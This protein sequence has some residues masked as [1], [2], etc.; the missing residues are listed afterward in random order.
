MT[1]AKNTINLAKRSAV[2][3]G[4]A[5]GIGYA[6]AQRLLQSGAA[7][8][9]WDMDA[10]LLDGAREALATEG[11]VSTVQLDVADPKA[12][13]DAVKASQ[14]AMGTIEIMV[15]CAG[16]AKAGKNDCG[17]LDGKH[18]CAGQATMDNSDQEWVYV[19]KGTCE[20]ITG[21]TV[22]AVKPAK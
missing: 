14:S 11:T 18:E 5:Q 4:G 20:K 19:P 16:I 15:A 1:A 12:V 17:A 22:A 13:A 8:S 3:T 2:V 9:L 10:K 7:V 21:G 6:V